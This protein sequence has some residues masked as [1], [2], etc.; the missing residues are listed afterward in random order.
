MDFA[1]GGGELW[2]LWRFKKA[3]VSGASCLR[4]WRGRSLVPDRIRRSRFCS[5]KR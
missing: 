3:P 4:Y 5:F 1:F 2:D